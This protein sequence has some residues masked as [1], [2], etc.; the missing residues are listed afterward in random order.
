M[1]PSQPTTRQ[2]RNEAIPNTTDPDGLIGI[3]LAATH[4]KT[5]EGRNDPFL[6]CFEEPFDADK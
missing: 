6:I 4:T 1:S 5:N 2:S 3:E